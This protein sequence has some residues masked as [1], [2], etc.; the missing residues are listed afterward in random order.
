M[1]ATSFRGPAVALGSLLDGRL[2]NTDGPGI[3]YQGD[4]VPDP[5]YSPANLLTFAPA[6]PA[7][8]NSPYVVMVDNFPQAFSTTAI[9]AAATV[10]SGTAM[11]LTTV[12]PNGSSGKPSLVTG[13]P[14]IPFQKSA[15]SLVNVI[16][17]DFG[18]ATATTVAG[19]ASVTVND[20]TLFTLG[21]WI[22]IGGAG[23]SGKTLSLVTQVLTIPDSTHITVS[24]TPASAMTTVPVGNA[25]AYA[26]S[27]AAATAA[28]PALGV[29]AEQVYNPV[30]GLARC[31]SITTAASGT[32]GVM[33]VVG[34]DFYG[35]QMSEDI[36]AVVNSTVFGQKAFKYILSV[37]PQF[38]DGSHNY[39]VGFGD[40]FGFH[41]RSDKWEYA[42][43]FYNGTYVTSSTGWLAGVTTSPSTR[44]TGDVRGTV[45]VSTQGNGSGISGGTN[46]TG[47]LRLALFMSVPAFNLFNANA[48]STATL[49]G[50]TQNGP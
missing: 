47:S 34:Y 4:C 9:A 6:I 39:S 32:G 44:T 49:Y 26:N 17:L 12:C 13:V 7:H 8:L 23:N 11:T 24:P 41:I 14:L 27:Q 38:T 25:N 20:S 40:T 19:T 30:E 29:G 10:A 28:N 43:I 22:V 45:Q 15:A 37:T 16:A 33:R 2:E 3:E 1:S 35:Q 50:V 18:F 42:N 21:Q 5:R 36:T 46:T 48:S 31:I